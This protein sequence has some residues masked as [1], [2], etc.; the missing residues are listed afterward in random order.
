MTSPHT[1]GRLSSYTILSTIIKMFGSKA[2]PV[3]SPLHSTLSLG[4]LKSEVLKIV[5]LYTL[6][7]KPKFFGSCIC[8]GEERMSGNLGHFYKVDI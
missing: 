6:L 3:N 1:D 4:S 8:F 5:L 2:I 7:K